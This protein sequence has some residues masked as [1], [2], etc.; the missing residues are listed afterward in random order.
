MKSTCLDSEARAGI[1]N[2]AKG[3]I[4]K[5][6]LNIFCNDDEIATRLNKSGVVT[7][8]SSRK[9]TITA[10]PYAARA[11]PRAKMCPVNKVSASGFDNPGEEK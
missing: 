10:K 5:A 3:V 9:R 11:R 8:M 1:N 2:R 6:V 7:K 4:S